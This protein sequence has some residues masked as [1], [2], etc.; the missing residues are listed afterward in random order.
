MYKRGE[1]TGG[2]KSS[3]KST[4]K[5]AGLNAVIEVMTV[6]HCDIIAIHCKTEETMGLK[7]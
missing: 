1:L 7:G 2:Q 5:R 3:W 4:T 6:L